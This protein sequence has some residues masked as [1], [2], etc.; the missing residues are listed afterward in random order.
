MKSSWTT[1]LDTHNISYSNSQKYSM[2]E[3][4]AVFSIRAIQ[5]ILYA[6]NIACTIETYRKRAQSLKNPCSKITWTLQSAKMSCS[7]NCMNYS[8]FHQQDRIAR[9]MLYFFHKLWMMSA[10]KY[11]RNAILSPLKTQWKMSTTQYLFF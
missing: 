6:M 11:D 5:W 7:E 3:C 1:V 9:C 10:T 2:Y 8:N 4:F